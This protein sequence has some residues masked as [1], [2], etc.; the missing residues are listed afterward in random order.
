MRKILVYVLT[1]LILIFL[2]ACA[3]ATPAPTSLAAPTTPSSQG[4][5]GTSSNS[6]YPGTSNNND[7]PGTSALPQSDG[8]QNTNEV[9]H[10][11]M[12]EESAFLALPVAMEEAKK[13]RPNAV[14]MQIPRLRQMENNLTLPEGPSGWFFSFMDTDGSSVELYVEVIGLEV[15]GKN[16]VQQLYPN[17]EPPFKL[18]PIDLTKKLIEHKDAFKIFLES[19]GNDYIKG[20]GRVELD[21]QL[22][23]LEGMDNPVWSIFNT[24]DLDAPPLINIDAVTGELVE[25]P[26]GFLR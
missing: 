13:W 9:D 7:Y 23:Q 17:G 4:S 18:V 16:E 14:I 26:F 6:D 21:F 20:K 5:S 22:L 8:Q 24:A 1:V 19:N 11:E 3:A 12:T 2:P 25:D 15:A 10:Y